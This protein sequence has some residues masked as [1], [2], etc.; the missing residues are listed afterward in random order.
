MDT[1]MISEIDEI[2]DLDGDRMDI[3]GECSFLKLN[4]S[5]IKLDTS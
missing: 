2:K 1:T 3:E 5:Q 4:N